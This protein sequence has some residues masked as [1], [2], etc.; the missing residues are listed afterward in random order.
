MN[1]KEEITELTI[2]EWVWVVFIILS[3]LNIY[4]DEEKKKFCLYQSERDKSISKKIFTFTVFISLLVYSYLAY[5]NYTRVTLVKDNPQKSKLFKTR[6]FG[7]ILVVVA[8]SLFLYVQL[9]NPD[10][11]NPSIQ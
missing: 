3:A 8:A 9:N 7:S 1:T 2:D 10:D 5:K 6:L 4:G 11:D